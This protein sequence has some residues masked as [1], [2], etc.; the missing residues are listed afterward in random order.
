MTRFDR[1]TAIFKPIN[2][3]DLMKPTTLILPALL[4]AMSGNAQAQLFKVTPRASESQEFTARNKA[5][6]A[7][8][9]MQSKG[10]TIASRVMGFGGEAITEVEKYGELELVLHEDFSLL[11]AG[12][13]AEPATN[14]KLTLDESEAKYPW[15]NFDPKYTHEPHWGVGGEAPGVACPAGGCLYMEAVSN[16]ET[17]PPSQA[18][19]NTTLVDVSKYDGTAVLEFRARTKNAGETYDCLWIEMAET[20]NMGESWHMPE[21]QVI[22]TGIPS[23]WTTYRIVFRDCGPTT[24]FNMVA[25]LPGNVYLDDIKVYQLKPN[26]E[27]PEVFSH[28][29]YKGISFVA[30]W[31]A[32][33]GATGY[34]LSVYHDVPSS[35]PSAPFG[36][37]EREYILTD[38]K[39]TDNKYTVSD[40]ESGET[41]Y[42]TVKAIDDKGHTSIESFP[43]R[44]Y[45]LEM[46]VMGD[47]DILND[48]TYTANWSEVPGAD[49]YN[50]FAF[51]KREAEAD[52]L[53]VVTDEDFTGI[54]DLEGNETGFTIESPWTMTYDVYYS[55]ELK[56][57][58]WKATHACPYTN[59][60]C[61]DAFFYETGGSQAGLTS[62]EFDFSKDGGKF[63][64]TVDLAGQTSRVEG[65]DGK[66]YFYTTQSCAA[67]FNWN[68]A[69]GDFEQVE[70]LYPE[71]KVT[72]SWQTFNFNFTKGTERSIVGIFAI[73]SYDNLY[74]DNLKITQNYKAGDYLIEPFR[75]KQ[76]H[77]SDFND[78]ATMI[79]IE[80]P[81]R[82]QGLDIYH[83]VSAFG[84]QVDKY[85]QSY[86]DRES[87]Y[88]PLAFVM[89]SKSGVENIAVDAVEATA[90]YFRIDG[91]RVASDKLTP[92][93]YVVRK[94]NTV[95]K[96]MVK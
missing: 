56:Q 61:L 7:P 78:I 89:S 96:Q 87:E 31:S 18:H 29:E 10:M 19:V 38:V 4:L 45:D 40:L 25:Y 57:Q 79:D 80:V 53:F 13:E 39:V 58:G 12:S 36:S 91:V 9:M 2:S 16:G 51:D 71:T 23:Q 17:K 75:F 55:R 1:A 24:I 88:T 68:D 70:L 93:V 37:T 60:L 34:L 81:E 35:D 64:V 47:V 42:Y 15:W 27:R 33:E 11:T 63:T 67:L 44:V 65:E 83:R 95:S 14:V 26:L 66:E 43:C 82:V 77:G 41:Y 62:P 3:I 85:G 54:C 20:N 92:G 72:G 48:W 46:P 28:S 32:V 5:A 73:G 94:G 74:V 50:Y 30:N 6:K 76:Y 22:V 52:G 49:V 8:M 21:E 90:E 69:L 59:F 86:D 84:R